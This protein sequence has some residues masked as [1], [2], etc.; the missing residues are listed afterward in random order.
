MGNKRKIG[1]YFEIPVKD[2]SRSMNF[3]SKIFE[4]EF[5]LFEIHGV[6]IAFFPDD[7]SIGISGGLA[8]GDI[9][10]PS[11]QGTLIYLHSS[12]IDETLK[13]V[14]DLGGKTL[15]Q[16]SDTGDFGYVAE[17]EDCEGN[18]IGLHQPNK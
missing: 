10:V 15:F 16:K 12:D 2:L 17:F 11:K 1:S 14:S 6:K 9:Y 5:T 18:R 8:Q 3:Y 13:K 4:L 7:G